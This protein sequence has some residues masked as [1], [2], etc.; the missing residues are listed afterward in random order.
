MVDG[1]VPIGQGTTID[2]QDQ[3]YMQAYKDY[4]RVRATADKYNQKVSAW[5]NM[6]PN[7]ITRNKL[8]LDIQ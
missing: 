5:N 2:A 6:D 1:R 3:E 8:L 4:K 7:N